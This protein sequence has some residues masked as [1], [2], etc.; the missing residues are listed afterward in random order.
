[1]QV[2]HDKP[3]TEYKVYMHT[4]PDGRAYVGCTGDKLQH[5]WRGGHGYVCNV[6]FFTD[7]QKYGW[8]AFKHE[9]LY[10]F[11]TKDEAERKEAELIELYDLTN[12][13]KGYNLD[14]GLGVRS[15]ETVAKIS[16]ALTGKPLSLE[17]RKRMSERRKGVKLSEERKQHMSR[18][19]KQSELVQA[20]MRTLHEMKKG[21]PHSEAHR[22]K[23]AESQPRRKCVRNL[24][25]GEV[26]TS[27]QDAAT[28]CSGSHPNITKVCKGERVRAYGYRWAYED[29]GGSA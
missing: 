26:F 18:V 17:R 9:V 2:K 29:G 3:H 10:T 21:V 16:S 27:V 23:I 19:A 4:S 22:R 6:H 20:H 5:R 7:I 11:S 28:S 25:T 1:M 24:D 12:P 14:P 15:P 13:E 8:G